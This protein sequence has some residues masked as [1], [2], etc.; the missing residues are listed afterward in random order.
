MLRY[1][2]ILS[3]LLFSYD[4]FSKSV[5]MPS[6]FL[7][8]EVLFRSSPFE[9]DWTKLKTKGSYYG[10]RRVENA[11][12][13]FLDSEDDIWNGY[14]EETNAPYGLAKKMLLVQSQAYRQQYNMNAI[15]L[16][17]VNLYGPGDNFD[18]NSGHVLPG[19]INKI[20][21][22]T[23]LNKKNVI[24]WG[25]GKPKRE[26]LFVDDLAD[27]LVFL[28]KKYN[29]NQHIN[30]GSGNEISILNLAKTIGQVIGFKG[31]F[32]F[33]KSKPDGTP[34][35]LI[36]SKKINSLGWKSKTNLLD[37]IKLTYE[38]YLKNKSK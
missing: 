8:P 19:L 31:K 4:S 21:N 28:M 36:N 9:T 27:A 14:P 10:G 24:I 32:I 15:T 38:S 17:P 6:P 16:F 33:D 2:L 7:N 37:G 22:A 23:K 34:R 26:F 18:V 12:E 35:K 3:F 20:H 25:T 1:L 30:V 11:T 13:V 5:V 29:Q